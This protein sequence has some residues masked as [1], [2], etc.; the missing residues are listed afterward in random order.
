MPQVRVASSARV[1]RSAFGTYV[2]FKLSRFRALITKYVRL[3]KPLTHPHPSPNPNPNPCNLILIF[4]GRRRNHHYHQLSYSSQARY[5][6]LAP[7]PPPLQPT[8]PHPLP[9]LRIHIPTRLNRNP[10]PRSH[11]RDL[12]PITPHQIRHINM[13]ARVK[14]KRRFRAQYFE[15]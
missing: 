6:L 5:R 4:L 14:L 9:S 8:H 10:L 7:K 3:P 13:L 1:F 11:P 12:N 15:M 2:Q